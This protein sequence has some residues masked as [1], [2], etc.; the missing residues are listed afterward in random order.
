[1]LAEILAVNVFAFLL[2]FVRIGTI[3][4]IMPGFSSAQ[5]LMQHRLLFALVVAFLLTPLLANK[6]PEMPGSPLALV[7]LVLGEFLAGAIL[8]TVARIVFASVQTAGTII[9]FVSGMANAMAYDAI[10]QAQSSLVSG[11]LGTTA[12]TVFFV[13]NMHHLVIQA[14][15]DS[16][17]LFLPGTTRI[18]GD[19]T[20]LISRHISLS[21][22]VGMQMATPFLIMSFAYYL[23]LGLLTRL[24]P[25]LP[26]FFVALPV[27]IVLSIATFMVA[28]ASIILAFLT[29]FQDSMEPFLAP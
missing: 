25:Q 18:I 19:V 3:L 16:Y 11:F 29:Y 26:I 22:K 23:A 9:S 7:A 12:V 4:L 5:V 14:M 13:T 1:M 27:Q 20:E 8:G 10:S 21:F 2:I 24:V 17:T 15:V 6:L 28:T